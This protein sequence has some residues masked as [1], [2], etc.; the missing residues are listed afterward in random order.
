MKPQCNLVD[1]EGNGWEEDR[2]NREEEMRVP[3]HDIGSSLL[4]LAASDVGRHFIERWN[5]HIYYCFKS[6]VKLNTPGLRRFRIPTIG[7]SMAKQI[8]VPKLL[9]QVQCTQASIPIAGMD[10][11]SAPVFQ[12]ETYIPSNV[13][14]IRSSST[15]SAGLGETDSSI[16]KTYIDLIDNAEKFVFIENQFFVTSTGKS[17]TGA[18]NTI[19]GALARRV[20]KA[21]RNNENFKIY[22]VIP[23]V[24]GMN[25]R[26]EENNA[27]AQ[28][29]L[30]HLTMESINRGKS[31]IK[32][33]CD[34]NHVVDWGNWISFCSYRRGS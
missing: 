20:V 25:G 14:I 16:L 15:W 23:C 5:S 21:E 13:Q 11:P 32:G 2:L 33:W 30:I 22:I 6:A 17:Q 8:I 28:E 27:Q 19:G 7:E 26:L 3:W 24:P 1:P 31:S 18:Q 29:V 10:I 12:A 9:S 34:D 4:G